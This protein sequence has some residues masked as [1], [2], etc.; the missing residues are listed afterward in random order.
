MPEYDQWIKKHDKTS[1]MKEAEEK[2]EMPD[3]LDQIR[4]LN[5]RRENGEL[6]DEKFLKERKKLM[7]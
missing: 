2:K 5:E 3:L 1:E 4:L 7:G 6:D